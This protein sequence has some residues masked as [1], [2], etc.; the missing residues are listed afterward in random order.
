MITNITIKN[1]KG[2]DSVGRSLD[3]NLKPKKLNLLVAPN[4]FGK[5]SIATAFS[6]LQPRKLNVDDTD[7]FK[8]DSS[9]NSMLSITMDG[10][11]YVADKGKND[12]SRQVFPF[13]IKSKLK[14]TTTSRTFNGHTLTKS[15]LDIDRIKVRDVQPNCN[16]KYSIRDIRRK[17]GK[18][19]KILSDISASFRD[20]YFMERVVNCFAFFEKFKTQARSNLIDTVLEKINK[21]SGTEEEI[22]QILEKDNT[23][24]QAIE[25]E[26][27]Y[28][29]AL[30]ILDNEKAKCP[31]DRFMLF[32]QLLALYKGDA[33]NLNNV[34]KRRKYEQ[35]K[36][37]VRQ[38]LN[39]LNNTW[40]DISVNETGKELV[41]SYPQ[42]DEISNGQRDILT[43]VI[44]LMAFES[45]MPKNRPSL[46]IIDEIF[47]YLDDANM[48]AAQYYL[49]HFIKNI[50]QD[51]Y[52]VILTHVDPANFRSYVFSKMLN[53]QMLLKSYPV[54]SEAMKAFI[55]FR[56]SLN[57]ND[58]N[59]K[60]LYDDLSHFFFHYAPDITDITAQLPNRPNLKKLWGRELNLHN[61]L[62]EECN[63]YLSGQ[64]TYDP[65][66]LCLGIRLRVEKIVYDSL[67]NEEQRRRFVETNE[68][69]KK[70][71]YGRECGV[72]IPDTYYFLSP[73]HNDAGHLKDENKD[74]A[75]ILKLQHLVI[76]QIIKSLFDYDDQ[77]LSINSIH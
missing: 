38:S 15:Y 60:Q 48:I 69:N 76:R 20:Y 64:E 3:L 61:Y 26:S 13:V 74:K 62:I 59:Q 36:N 68:T 29:N 52:V 40:K 46:L 10:K 47:D 58:V 71:D 2:F 43:F 5:T 75:C 57:K 56:E 66:A 41:V 8:K 7:K 73:I 35:M 37:N 45:I 42:A 22:R 49:S 67:E 44:Q 31:L 9:L 6:C 16:L 14:P 18:N 1:I 70:M 21:L 51:V 33:A 55:T 77:P 53:V 11:D 39:M 24:F 23:C 25:S 12:I 30:T 27:N 72:E 34:F 28:H 65:Y 32:Y 63:K 4:G 17:F 54:G 50:E 19:G